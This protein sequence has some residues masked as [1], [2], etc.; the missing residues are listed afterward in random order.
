[1]NHLKMKLLYDQETSEDG[2]AVEHQRQMVDVLSHYLGRAVSNARLCQPHL[3]PVPY[4]RAIR[5]ALDG[6][7]EMLGKHRYFT[8]T[9]FVRFCC[10]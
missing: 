4:H 5:H 8:E 6:M 1:M 3:L 2:Q 7:I 10:M 9:A